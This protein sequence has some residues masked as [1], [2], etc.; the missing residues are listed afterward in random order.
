MRHLTRRTAGALAAAA[1]VLALASGCSGGPAAA[2]ADSAAE[3][4][5]SAAPVVLP[6][7]RGA[8]APAAVLAQPAK[9]GEVRI[10]EGPFT[11][12]VKMTALKLTD[13]ASVTGHI[14]ITSDVSDTLALEIGAAYYDPTGHLLGT[15]KFQYQEEGE[16][17]QGDQHHDGPRAA[18]DGIDFTVPAGQFAQAPA[19]VVLS[20]PVLVSE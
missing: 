7:P 13:K 20:I 9:P 14:A 2:T 8:P 6:A 4:A 18:G 16:D 5:G 19:S 10:E 11:D 12:R 15:T 1:A 3:A 17:A